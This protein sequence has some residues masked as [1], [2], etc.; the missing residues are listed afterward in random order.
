VRFLR[1][2]NAVA[3]EVL[4]HSRASQACPE[5]D[6]NQ[7]SAHQSPS[8]RSPRDST[9][10]SSLNCRLPSFNE[11]LTMREQ[12]KEPRLPLRL[13]VQWNGCEEKHPDVT[14]DVSLGGCYVES[15]NPVT[16]GDVLTLGFRLPF[17]DTLPVRCEVRYHQPTIGFGLRFLN[18]SNFQ[19]ASLEGL[20][21]Y[22]GRDDR[23]MKAA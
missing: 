5:A 20:I 7:F 9:G 1:R 13:E 22:W 23:A 11:D 17:S 10:T 19:R 8:D 16:V 21:S 4:N 12:R 3:D 6:A 15:L 14:S 18:L 2:R